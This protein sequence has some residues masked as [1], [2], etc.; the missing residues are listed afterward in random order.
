MSLSHRDHSWVPYISWIEM[1]EG[2]LDK[3]RTKHNVAEYEVR[4]AFQNTRE[5]Q[6][7]VET[8]ED[9]NERIVIKGCT[10][11]GRRL[12]GILYPMDDQGGWRI[13]TCMDTD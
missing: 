5:V 11:K 6:A 3:L 12:I 7:V 1:P 10:Y 9:D 4:E 13:A 8:D 2:I